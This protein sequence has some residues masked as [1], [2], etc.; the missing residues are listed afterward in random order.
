MCL[1]C[2]IEAVSDKRKKA[3]SNKAKRTLL[4]EARSARR[5]Q[6]EADHL[7]MLKRK[8][9]IAYGRI[10]PEGAIPADLAQQSKN[11]SYSPP[12]YY[13]DQ[14][15]DCVD[16]RKSEVWTASQQKWYYEVAKGSIYGRAIRCRACRKKHRERVA[17]RRARSQ[18]KK[19][20]P[21]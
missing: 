11:N 8:G 6:E 16:C 9:R 21:L 3:T 19:G 17:L 2:R 15:F 7:A 10:I 20:D 5:K 12:I 1:C 14:P 13:V 4:T 18:R